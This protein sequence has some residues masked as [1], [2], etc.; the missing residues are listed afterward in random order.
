M[1]PPWYVLAMVAFAVFVMPGGIPLTTIC[2][3]IYVRHRL[4]TLDMARLAV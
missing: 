1:D 3:P 2:T 4:R